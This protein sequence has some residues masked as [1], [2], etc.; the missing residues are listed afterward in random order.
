MKCETDPQLQMSMLLAA[1]VWPS[2]SSGARYHSAEVDDMDSSLSDSSLSIRRA[3][4]KFDSFTSP[5]CDRHT[6]TYSSSGP[7][8]HIAV[9]DEV[10]LHHHILICY[11]GPTY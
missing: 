8:Y 1:L 5:L 9:V 10:S 2:S 3:Q 6:H 4:L 7:W 11:W